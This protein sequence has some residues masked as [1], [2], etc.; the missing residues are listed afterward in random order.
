[1]GG[2]L[3]TPSATRERRLLVVAGEV[4]GDAHAAR[5]VRRLQSLGPVA[6]HAVAGPALRAAG[7][8]TIV[9]QED[10]AVIGFSGVIAKLP[11]I[12]R[13][14]RAILA[15]VERFRPEVAL[16]VDYP[17]FNLRLGPEL[18]RRGVKVFY[19]IAPQVWAWHAERAAEMAA[20]VDRLAVVFPF[21]EPLFRAAGVDAHFVGHPL[22]DELA[23][24]CDAATF[25]RELAVSGTAPIVG[26]LA[27]SRKGEVRAH[28]RTLLEA[29]QRLRRSHPDVV[30]VLALATGRDVAEFPRTLLEGVRVV[31]GRTHAVQAHATCCA[32]ASGTATLETALLGSP[33]VIV[34]RVG[35]INHA[36]AKRVIKLTH[37]GLPN[38]VAGREV[39]PELIQQAFT[40]EAV[41]GVLARWLDDPDACTA[42]RAGLA[43]VR[44][45]LGQRGASERAAALLA[46]MWS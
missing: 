27:G 18:K 42:Q 33:H 5:L 2:A 45:R 7:A 3:S 31:H 36:I 17:G 23:P 39:A 44:E 34:Y 28:G 29:A 15:D 26:L 6:V 38:I 9:P 19:Y 13:A 4:S 11:V 21:E 24:E 14:R 8:H 16:L 41:A 35:W 46:G 30:P 40:A 20:W 37:I 10:L 12:L 1:M 22:L 25:R 43:Q 32:V